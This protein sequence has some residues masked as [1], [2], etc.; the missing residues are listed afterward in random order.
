MQ[1]SL[2]TGI[3]FSE[4]RMRGLSS[5]QGTGAMPRDMSFPVPKG[6]SWH[7]LYDYI[8]YIYVVLETN[9]NCFKSR[10]VLILVPKEN[11]VMS[12]HD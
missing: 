10:L 2:L 12:L 8:R 11:D 1:S 7:D 3:S 6:C 4:A 5:S 9:S